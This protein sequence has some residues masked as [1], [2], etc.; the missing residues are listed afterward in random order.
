MS[1]FASLHTHVKYRTTKKYDESPHK[2]TAPTKAKVEEHA[3]SPDE[4]YEVLEMQV[5]SS[6]KT[7]YAPAV[8][9]PP[10]ESKA[11]KNSAAH[12]EYQ[13]AYVNFD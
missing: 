5:T 1:I 7:R 10:V 9:L 6:A 4:L 3:E 13:E 2:I 11:C 12:K 8:Q